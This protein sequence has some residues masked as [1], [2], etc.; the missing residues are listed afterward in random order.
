MKTIKVTASKNYEITVGTDFLNEAGAMIRE[1]AGGTVAA[2]VTDDKVEALYGEQLGK[3]LETAGYSVVKYV[4][5]NGEASKN[6]ETYIS[7]IN[8]LAANKLSRTDVVIALGGGVP[9]DIAG[10][11]AATYKRGMRFVQIP[12]TLLAAVDSSV[13]GKTAVNL[14]DGKNLLGAFYQPDLVLCDTE[15]LSTISPEVYRDGCAEIIKYGVIADRELFESLKAGR[16]DKTEEPSL[17]LEE[18]SLC[19]QKRKQENRPLVLKM[20]FAVVWKLSG[21]L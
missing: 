15:L 6:T 3:S 14:E 19:L 20:L 1:K 16:R 5:P 4:F 18:P 21:I 17:C 2:I 8:F 9:G 13:G 12:T 11:A 10:F 7:L